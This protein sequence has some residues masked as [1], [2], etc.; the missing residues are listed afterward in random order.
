MQKVRKWKNF[1]EPDV[2]IH[3]VFEI[4]SSFFS[5]FDGV[6]FKSWNLEARERIFFRKFMHI[7]KY[8]IESSIFYSGRE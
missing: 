4:T 2:Y 6:S 8:N 3:V 7:N 1:S 5:N